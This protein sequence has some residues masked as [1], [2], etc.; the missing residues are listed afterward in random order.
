MCAGL[1]ALR[2]LTPEEIARINALGDRLRAGVAALGLEVH[3]RG[4]LS[5]AAIDDDLWWRLYRAGVLV[6]RHGLMCVS[7]PMD[8]AA[9]DEV[10]ERFAR[11][12]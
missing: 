6:G 5:R 8:D 12:V 10:L 11:A 2:L 9:I 1:A 7:T 4:S 3:G